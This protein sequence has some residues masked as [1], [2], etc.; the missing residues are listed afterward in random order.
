MKSHCLPVRVAEILAFVAL[1]A[2]GQ[3]WEPVRRV[4]SSTTVPDMTAAGNVHTVAIRRDT[5]H[6]VYHEGDLSLLD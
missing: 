5:I 1:V 4:T 2:A 3:P 6:A